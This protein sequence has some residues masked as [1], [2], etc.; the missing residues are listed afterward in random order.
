MGDNIPKPRS[1]MNPV[2]LAGVV[3]QVLPRSQQTGKLLTRLHM[4]KQRLPVAGVG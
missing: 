4:V 3:E 2:G 1:R